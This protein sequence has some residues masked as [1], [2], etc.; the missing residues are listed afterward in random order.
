[1]PRLLPVLAGNSATSLF[2]QV[3]HLVVIVIVVV[4]VYFGRRPQ[5]SSWPLVQWKLP[6]SAAACSQS[7]VCLSVCVCQRVWPT[8][9]NRKVPVIIL[10]VRDVS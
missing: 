1:M 5:S 7:V 4:V 6:A 8:N 2:V 3:L 10:L 9:L